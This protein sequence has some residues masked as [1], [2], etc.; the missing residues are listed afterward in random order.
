M[1]VA[2]E[3][4]VEGPIDAGALRSRLL[5]PGLGGVAVF[6]GRV[7]HSEAGQ[8]IQGLH[9]EHYPRM[10]AAAMA[11]VLAEAI[12][13]WPGGRVLAQQRVGWVPVGEIALWVGC[14]YAHR[15]EAF[16]ACQWVIDEVKQAVP[17]WKASQVPGSAQRAWAP[18]QVIRRV[19]G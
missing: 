19:G 9:Y 18:G 7:R 12:R 10:A 15:A 17:V 4:I 14:A 11:Q 16:A 2:T 5:G 6:E 8:P 1:S 3:G 13:R